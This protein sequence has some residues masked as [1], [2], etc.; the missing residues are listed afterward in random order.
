MGKVYSLFENLK[1]APNAVVNSATFIVQIRM[2]MV[3]I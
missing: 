3:V 2:V 1:E